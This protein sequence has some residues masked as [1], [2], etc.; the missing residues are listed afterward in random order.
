[1]RVRK[2]QGRK[3]SKARKHVMREGR[4][5]SAQVTK[6]RRCVRPE[7][8]QARWRERHVI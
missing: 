6:A 2:D 8:T 3:A 7:D 1:M 4:R 5:K